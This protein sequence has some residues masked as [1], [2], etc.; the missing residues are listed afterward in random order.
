[1]AVAEGAAGGGRIAAKGRA[2]FVVL[3]QNLQG[4]PLGG[5]PR[6]LD[7]GERQAVDTLDTI[8]IGLVNNM[9]DS[10]LRV[11]ERQF[12]RLLTDAAGD[13]TV[14]LH[15]FSIPGIPRGT[16]E[17]PFSR[18]MYADISELA[19]AKL[20]GLI[21]TGCE[22]RA[23][24][25]SDEPYWESLT[26]VVDWAER[27]TT[28]TLWSCLAAHAAVLH[29]D[30]VERQRLDEKRF[31]VFE[32]EK[33]SDDPLLAGMRTP[34]RISHSR[35]N[36]LPEAKLKA[37]GYTILTRSE[38]AGVDIFVRR[39]RSLFLFFQGHPEYTPYSLMREYRRDV[40]R[41]LRGES[42]RYPNLPRD[43]FNQRTEEELAAF[44]IKAVAERDPRLLAEFPED[45][46][47]RAKLIR[48]RLVSG[49][50]VISNWLSYVASRKRE[51]AWVA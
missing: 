20:D 45:G 10:A 4:D 1:M 24:R 2:L 18:A 32:C 49:G 9:P 12:M 43:Y 48:R 44:A 15:F 36:E 11:T 5:E 8:E 37:N 50:P 3:N 42:T 33:A 19:A 38:A 14:R 16:L 34:L 27:N 47:L 46:A 26:A 39:R 21:V 22:P 28:S 25:L 30:G 51:R 41:Y 40:G 29:L 13:R 7:V 35:W 31:G 17:K 23:E 6:R